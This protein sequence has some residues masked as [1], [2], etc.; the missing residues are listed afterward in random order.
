MTRVLAKLVNLLICELARLEKQCV[1][2]AD[3]AQIVGGGRLSA[4]P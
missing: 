4:T 2:H 3:L 1:A